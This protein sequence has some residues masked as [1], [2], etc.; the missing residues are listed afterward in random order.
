[1]GP[2]VEKGRIVFAREAEG[3]DGRWRL[4][5]RESKLLGG[6]ARPWARSARRHRFFNYPEQGGRSFAPLRGGR[7][8]SRYKRA[9]R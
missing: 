3:R 1:M 4:A 9:N 8:C 7:R 5:Q 6:S 2:N